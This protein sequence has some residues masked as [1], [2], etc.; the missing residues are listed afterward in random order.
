M[1]IPGYFKDELAGKEMVE[2]IALR[3]KMYAYSVRS[4]DHNTKDS[5]I[6]KL[7]G[8]GRHVVKTSITLNDYKD[9]L[10][11]KKTFAHSMRTLRSEKHQMYV[12]EI[13]KK[14]LSPFDDKQFIGEDGIETKPFGW[15]TGPRFGIE[16]PELFGGGD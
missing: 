10:F 11:N 4:R 5:E 7:K 13:F 8:M 1:K 3:S 15:F 14:S 9:S 12:E 16:E 6:I 2:F